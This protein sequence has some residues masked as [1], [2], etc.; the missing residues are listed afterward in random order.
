LKRGV[1]AE[2]IHILDTAKK[3]TGFSDSK[4]IE[5][6]RISSVDILH[7]Q[8]LREALDD[9][10]IIVHLA[11]ATSVSGSM[12]N[13]ADDF[14]INSIGTFNLLEAARL[15]PRR[16]IVFASSVSGFSANEKVCETTLPAP[17]SPYGASK[18]H[19]EYLCKAWSHSFDLR[20]AVMRLTNAYG[21]EFFSNHGVV[22]EAMRSA[23]AGSSFKLYGSGNASR[24]FIFTED[25][26]DAIYKASTYEPIDE[27][28]AG[29]FE[30]YQIA[31]GKEITVNVLLEKID[32][33]LSQRGLAPLVIDKQEA[34][35]GEIDASCGNSDKAKEILGW[36]SNTSLEE[37]LSRTLDWYL[38]QK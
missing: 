38:A 25:I 18:L 3:S 26:C 1:D 2:N 30:L 35:T 33:L 34:R 29:S 13:P 36:S 15:K 31:S 11:A 37:G 22:S 23:V 7:P 19:G 10:D 28:T 20:V 27:K 32:L 6:L 9:A 12:E 16:K 8:A 5:K 4:T 14:Q 24:D 17:L 21:P